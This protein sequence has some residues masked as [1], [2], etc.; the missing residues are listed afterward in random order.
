MEHF[1]WALVA[2]VLSVG[3]GLATN[4][5]SGRDSLRDAIPWVVMCVVAM[6]GANWAQRRR[7]AA[8]AAGTIFQTKQELANRVM[9]RATNEQKL[10]E[11]RPLIP[12]KWNWTQDSHRRTPD[13]EL[14][15]DDIDHL[16]TYF[17]NLNSNQRRLVITGDSGT[18]KTSLVIELVLKLIELRGDTEPVPVL[19]RATEWD[20]GRHKSLQ[21]WLVDQLRAHFD[22]GDLLASGDAAR[23][24]AINRHLLPILDN[25]EELSKSTR[26]NILKR[27]AKG[28]KT[29]TQQVIIVSWRQEY[30]VAAKQANFRAPV[31]TA[32]GVDSNSAA[33]YLS[34][35][36]RSTGWDDVLC[37][38]QNGTAEGLSEV[39]STPWG[40]WQIRVVYLETDADPRTLVTVY[41]DDPQG[42]RAHLLESVVDALLF[43]ERQ[44]YGHG[45]MRR[46]YQATKVHMWLARIARSTERPLPGSISWWSVVD[47]AAHPN[48]AEKWSVANIAA[49]TCVALI[50]CLPVTVVASLIRGPVFGVTLG[51]VFGGVSASN[52]SHLPELT[53]IRDRLWRTGVI[54]IRESGDV[55]R[56]TALAGAFTVPFITV[57]QGLLAGFGMAVLYLFSVAVGI[58]RQQTKRDMEES[59]HDAEPA[60]DSPA[61]SFAGSGTPQ[62][63]W[64]ASR[65]LFATH[66]LLGALVGLVGVLLA[67]LVLSVGVDPTPLYEVGMGLL[68]GC[69]FGTLQRQLSGSWILTVT[70]LFFLP[71]SRKLP[72][73]LADFLDDMHKLGLLRMSGSFYE[74]RHAELYHHM[75]KTEQ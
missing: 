60:R 56:I 28:K 67:E 16:A 36:N 58:R 30:E 61:P 39:A 52:L 51:L 31:I 4:I 10:L 73:R 43:R 57:T 34:M 46:T 21:D 17:R 40:L 63:S 55:L 14:G 54:W 74:F 9:E 68:I 12:T 48:G 33:N 2:G 8:A 49:R 75:I 62:S 38:L 64:R 6:L 5:A 53:P 37:A 3:A 20:I 72:L 7:E 59:K 29:D 35:F 24:L 22:E 1:K 32:K 26:I 70:T 13:L 15:A 44:M 25:F 71:S 11:L 69:M 41:G 50:Y 47:R 66:M 42:L 65:A 18:G 27:L 45:Q 23:T 19:L